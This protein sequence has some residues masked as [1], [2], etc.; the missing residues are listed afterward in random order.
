MVLVQNTNAEPDVSPSDWTVVAQAGGIGS[1]GAA[2]AAATVSVGTVTTLA[3]GM[4]ATVTNTGT[5]SAAVL[6][7]GIPQGATGAAG[8][9]GSGTGA[10]SGNFA[11]MFHAV[12]F[13]ATFYAVN[14]T[15]ASTVETGTTAT[16]GV[17]AW[18]P[19]GCT[20][21]QLNVYS[22]Q[23]NTIAVTLRVGSPGAMVN[24]ALTCS[25]ATNAS[26]TATGSV[27]VGPGQFVDYVISGASGNAAGVWTALQC[28]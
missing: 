11:A 12:S 22:Q 28:Q 10:A 4:P 15:N 2:G 1:T 20:A 26:C 16:A 5:A 18:V 3:A 24:S 13:N 14:S 7:F 9:G 17:L 6:N 8:S 27:I 23:G 25:V 19:L 21:T